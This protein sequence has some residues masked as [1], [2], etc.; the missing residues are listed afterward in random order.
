MTA[1]IED[2][3]NTVAEYETLAIKSG[4]WDGIDAPEFSDDG[5]TWSQVWPAGATPAF[6]RVTVYRKNVRAPHVAVIAWAESLPALDEWRQLWERKPM[7]MFGSA[8]K[9]AAIRHAFREVVGD[10]RDA[11]ETDPSAPQVGVA[12]A[13]V[14]RRDWAVA[15][16]LAESVADLDALW[17]HAKSLRERT[18]A[19]EVAYTRRRGELAAAPEA[20][21]DVVRNSHVIE[22]PV[23]QEAPRRTAP[24]DH[25]PPAHGNRA[26]RRARKKGVRRGR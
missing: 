8:A 17:R 9:R 18:P 7:T 26:A 23:S 3:A 16:D 13:S 22:E 24:R 14:E 12:T 20:V 5:V 21:V 15:I 6:A 4:E 19:L 25:L 11:D 10:R 2:F 1:T